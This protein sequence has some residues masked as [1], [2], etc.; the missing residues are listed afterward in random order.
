MNG[1]REAT[2]ARRAWVRRALLWVWI[3][4]LWNVVEAA[5]A[6]YAGAAAA[7]VSLLAF[8]VKSVIEIGLGGILI[9][10]LRR[11]LSARDAQAASERRALRLL[12]L[13]FHVLA[14]FV[15]AQTA[16]T[17]VGWLDEPRESLLGIALVLGS[18]ALMTP[19][20]FAK[21]RLASKLGS[22][23]LQK[24]AVAT[25]GCDLQDLT[26]VVGLGLNSLFGWWWADAVA[27]LLLIP[28][29]VRE[30]R[31]AIHESRTATARDPQAT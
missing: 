29:L 4:E 17:L 21:S 15:L 18:A 5:V 1:A 6:L 24:E 12:G 19:L 28:F 23:S 7:S 3:G 26:V 9:W 22:R 27:A 2:P 11:E 25:L 20:Y 14:V 13:A 10:Q 8:G 31:E 16:G 30:G